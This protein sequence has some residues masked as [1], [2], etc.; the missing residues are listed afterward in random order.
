[1]NRINFSLRTLKK[2]QGGLLAFIILVASCSTS[3]TKTSSMVVLKSSNGSP[4]QCNEMVSRIRMVLEPQFGEGKNVGAIVGIYYQGK[5]HFIS[6]G[7]TQ[8]GNGR[9][10][11]EETL[12]EIG[13]LTKTFTGLLLAQAID[14]GVVKETTRLDEIK[15]SWRGQRVS[16]V[17]LL[18]LVTHRSGLPRLPCNLHYSTSD[19]PYADYS[20]EDL[21]TGLL[22]SSAAWTSACA[23]APHPSQRVEYSNWGMGLLGYILASVSQATY[24]E[25]LRA[26]IALPLNLKDTTYH[27]SDSQKKRMAQ[28]YAEN[29][30]AVPLWDRQVL[31]GNGAIRST[32][33][34]LMAYA[35]AHLRPENSL[36]A[37]A[38]A[39]SHSIHFE[40]IEDRI[41]YAWFF[42]PSGSYWHNGMTG[43]FASMMKVYPSRDWAVFYLTNTARELQCFIEAVEGMACTPGN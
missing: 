26:N 22:D 8:F 33:A 17:T 25:L 38:L 18:D 30:R 11:N 29:G 20:E 2:L 6:F 27:L 35:T 24:P 19:N 40:T 5:P 1:M 23:L 32:A 42:T 16:D 36:L 21:V 14:Q 7:E 28:G 3:S 41:G 9:A 39:R 37:S 13:S 34:D 15:S 4:V 10:P 43:G 12:F 31:F